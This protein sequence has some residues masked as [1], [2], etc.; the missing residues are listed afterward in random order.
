MKTAILCLFW[1]FRLSFTSTHVKI[2]SN[3]DNPLVPKV[4]PSVELNSSYGKHIPRKL[5]IAVKDRNDELPA[6]LQNLFKRN[7]LWEII[8]CDNACKDEFIYGFF[9]ETSVA[10]AYSLI[11]PQIGASKADIWRYSVLY[12]FGGVYL[13]DDSDIQ[14]P[15]DDIIQ[16]TDRLIMSEEGSSSLGECFVPNYSLSEQHTSNYYPNYTQAVHYDGINPKTNQPMFFHDHTLVNWGLFVAPRHPLLYH[17]LQHIVEII[18][19]E[20]NKQSFIHMTRWD[21]KW[22]LVMCSTGF[23]LTYSL[24]ELECQGALHPEENARILVNNYKKYHGNVKAIWTGG[25]AS[26]YMK[27]MQKNR[28]MHLLAHYN[29]SVPLSDIVRFLEHRAVMGDAGRDI[30]YVTQ[31]KKF[32]FPSYDLFLFCNFTDSQVRHI[33]DALLQQIPTGGELTKDRFFSSWALSNV[34]TEENVSQ[35]VQPVVQQGGLVNIDAVNDLHDTERFANLSSLFGIAKALQNQSDI[36]CFGDDY[37]GSRDD[38]LQDRYALQLQSLSVMVSPFCLRTFQLGNTLG[39]YFNNIACADLA[40]SHFI[41]T[42]NDFNLLDNTSLA[43]NHHLHSPAYSLTLPSTIAM[44][45]NPNSHLD[46]AQ[47]TFF[48]HLPKILYH[49]RVRSI[50]ESKQIMQTKCQCLQFCW[51]NSEAPWLSRIPLIRQAL[52]PAIDAYTI[53]SKAHALGTLLNNETDLSSLVNNR[54]FV[55]PHEELLDSSPLPLVPNVTIQ[56]RCGDNVGFG[57]SKY[58]LLPFSAYSTQRIPPHMAQYIY[59][60]ADSPTRNKASVYSSRCETILQH[61]YT[62]LTKRF[63]ESVVVIKRGGDVFLDYARLA[64]SPI[65][66]CSASTFCLWPALANTAGQVYFP[67][68]PLIAKA[69]DAK[70][71]PR[72]HD[73]FHWIEDVEMIKDF[74][75]YRPWYKVIDD[76]EKISSV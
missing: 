42:V 70:T 36:L 53:A 5:W 62:T 52:I 49:S 56:Y 7:P 37:D 13:D 38:F 66:F 29:H 33:N 14:T 40:G 71:A 73:H 46:N 34:S 48:H 10:W 31:G 43:I 8:I 20:Y 23:V 65:V 22:K 32:T 6:H 16:A 72:L 50:A 11:N 41:A 2:H 55:S 1:L 30:F 51:E 3:L 17:T 21:A 57:R 39:Y 35:P 18:S 60:I 15:F 67:L 44:G 28:A 68:T 9:G 64:Y 69:S 76:L 58:G 61:L 26:H 4:L 19:S 24:R 74:R 63:P 47:Y 25:D 12:T 75:H 27:L 54:Q 59:V 45:Y